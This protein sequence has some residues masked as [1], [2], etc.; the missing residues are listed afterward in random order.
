M[1]RRSVLALAGSV[2]LGGC[3]TVGYQ[4]ETEESHRQGPRSEPPTEER[5]TLAEQGFPPTV[6]EEAPNLD[7][8]HAIRNPA[9]SADWSGVDVPKRYR[10]AGGLT[11]DSVALGLT[12]GGHVQAYPL[13]VLR[14]HEVVNDHLN[15]PV[16][17]TYCPL[18]R[19]GMVAERIVAGQ[20]TQ[21]GVSG[22]L[23]KPPTLNTR[24]SEQEGRVFGIGDGGSKT[25][26]RNTG[27]LVLYGVATGSY[28]SQM[29]A[30]AICGPRRGE[31]LRIVPSTVTTWGEWRR[32]HPETEVLLPP[33]HS[34]AGNPPLS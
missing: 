4:R 15:R 21:F 26:V 6:C 16:M 24:S 1:D 28:W 19:S 27:N 20:E 23:W 17:V 2:A 34:E 29:L 14:R 25:D 32:D 30:R 13:A 3:M 5:V 33:P 11:A 10:R 22:Q 31:A 12:G 8:V 9:F 7:L 18:C